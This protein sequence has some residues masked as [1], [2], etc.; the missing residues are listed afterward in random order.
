MDSTIFLFL[1]QDG[2]TNGAVYALLGFALVL[3]FAV[4]RIVLIPQG[5]FVAYGGLTYAVLQT[6][7]MPGTVWLMLALGVAAFVLDVVAWRRELTRAMLLRALATQIGLPLA[8]LGACKLAAGPAGG[9]MLHAALTIA[10]VGAI[11]PYLYRIAFEPM[12]DASV[13]TLFITAMGVHLAMLG[14]GL[15]LFGPEGLRA[16]PLVDLSVS[17]GPLLVSGQSLVVYLA[18]LG[19]MVSLYLFFERTVY[20]KALRAT[21]MNRVGA[22]LV[23]IRLVLSGRLALALAAAI[24]AVSG[25]LIVPATTLY[26]D[27]G[28]LIGLKG[29][30]AAII[31]GLVSHPVTAVAALVVG[32]VEAFAA[33]FASNFKEVIVFTLLLPVLVWRSIAMPQAEEE[34]E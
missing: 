31:G 28:F 26:Y 29:F 5:E 15:V 19:L 10:I 14:L 13:L 1:V 4:T 16:P 34:E 8:I 23:G 33:F 22:R 24:G 7:H 20:G 9:P 11:G 21:A 3:V 25:I 32:L 18:A 17:A 30:V 12:A 27:T 6:G 2:I